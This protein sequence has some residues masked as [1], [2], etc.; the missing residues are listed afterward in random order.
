MYCCIVIYTYSGKCKKIRQ[1][2]EIESARMGY[3]A[4]FGVL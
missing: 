3:G 4:A 2:K 1:T